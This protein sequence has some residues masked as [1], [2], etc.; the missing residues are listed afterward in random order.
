MIYQTT[1]KQKQILANLQ[2][3]LSVAQQ[4][5][6]LAVSAMVAGHADVAEGAQV[7]IDTEGNLVI[8]DAPKEEG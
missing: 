1:A 7:S 8:A 2:A 4:R 3:D 6:S 5:F